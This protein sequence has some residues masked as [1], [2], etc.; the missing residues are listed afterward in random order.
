MMR[1]RLVAVIVCAFLLSSVIL[2][3]FC[4]ADW[5]TFHQN[6][7]HTGASDSVAV[8]APNQLWNL[9][10]GGSP[11]NGSPAVSAGKVVSIGIVEVAIITF[12][13]AAI[14]IV[15]RLVFGRRI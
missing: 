14:I 9:S 15:V 5:P 10:A 7:A 2:V 13:V 8:L 3:N 1:H 11:I 4:N 6:I 12:L